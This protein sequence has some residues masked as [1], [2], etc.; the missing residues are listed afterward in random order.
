MIITSTSKYTNEKSAK[1]TSEHCY[2]LTKILPLQVL[3]KEMKTIQVTK[4]TFCLVESNVNMFFRPIYF[5]FMVQPEKQLPPPLIR[6]SLSYRYKNWI[7]WHFE[8][9][10]I[11]VPGWWIAK[12]VIF[13]VDLKTSNLFKLKTIRL[14]LLLR[15]FTRFMTLNGNWFE[16]VVSIHKREAVHKCTNK[17]YLPEAKPRANDNFTCKAKPSK[18]K[19]RC[20]RA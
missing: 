3:S 15:M 19:M 11:I 7:L 5:I 18:G 20:P 14:R 17:D 4:L 2:L 13:N 1:K 6:D 8:A 9:E 10:Y 16:M 12:L